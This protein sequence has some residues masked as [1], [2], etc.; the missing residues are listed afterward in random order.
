MIERLSA[1]RRR[2]DS[3][4]TLIELLVVIVI[5]G[6]LAGVV[7]FSVNGVQ[8]K[9]ETAA[10]KTDERTLRTAQEAFYAKFGRYAASDDELAEKGFLAAPSTQHDTA[11]A[12]K[13]FVI[14]Y[15]QANDGVS[16]GGWDVLTL[17]AG[18]DNGYPTPFQS[19]RGP[20]N[21]NANYL[22][23]P[24]LWR[25]STGEALPWLAT[26]WERSA[27]GLQ[28][29]FTLRP[30]VRWQG[31]TTEF[32]TADDVVFTFDY[33][34]NATGVVAGDVTAVKN[35]NTMIRDD[36]T[37]V[38]AVPGT[39]EK[40][41]FTLNKP[42][43]TFMTRLAQSLLILPRHIW[44]GISNPM[45]AAPAN[46]DVFKGTGA[47]VLQNPGGYTP[48]TGVSEY[49]ANPDFFLGM[50][51]VRKLRFITVNDEIG[52]LLN[53]DVSAGGIGSEESVTQAALDTVTAAGFNKIENPG[54]WN[55]AL[56]FNGL[57][58]FPFNNVGF[59]KAVAYTVDRAGLLQNIVG[60]RGE[61]SNL[62]GLA[63]SHPFLAPN[64]PAYARDVVQAKTL[65]DSLGIVDGPDGD[66]IRELP[67]T[68][69]GS[70]VTNGGANFNVTLY[71]SD[72][73]S[74]DTVEAVQ[75]Y[76]LDV[77]LA[78]TYVVEPSGTADTRAQ[79]KNYEMAFVGYGNLTSDPDQLRTRF[80]AIGTSFS[81]VWGWAPASTGP[82]TG[83]GFTVLADKQLIEPDPA[84]RR[85]QLH[86]MQ[87]I[88][89][90]EVPLISLYSPFST[91][92]YPPGGFSAW[93]STPGGTP[94]GP[95][96]F[97]NKHVFITGKQFGL[98]SV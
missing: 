25:D 74:N 10:E 92:F 3:G 90:A 28:W 35:K 64:L 67:A 38:T 32:L 76:L 96:G 22:F 42:V 72:R 80:R 70:P 63:P 93:Y 75:Q 69:G 97:S 85:D 66:S 48:S 43:N 52:Q 36:V 47:Y 5:L 39:P 20:G 60:G 89:A 6:I 23:D 27:D 86:D 55:R 61:L 41:V 51:Y 18:T 82:R 87:D 77:G 58:G 57:K 16:A 40:V 1:A 44:Q 45:S 29:T 84:A 9:G 24:L 34:K 98:P 46:T 21:L 50:P 71:T 83:L 14:G 17:A 49:V 62:G 79:N 54:G 65:L 2:D 53:G 31:S 73:F 26:A 81:N 91:I 78:S 68:F 8:D 88:I 95:P 13:S 59:R 4:F 37:S 56:H 33:M 7:V 11:P 30:N 19:L 12:G 94:P 15:G